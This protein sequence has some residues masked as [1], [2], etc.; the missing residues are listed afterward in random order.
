MKFTDRCIIAFLIFSLFVGISPAGS[1]T[2]TEAAKPVTVVITVKVK[3][4]EEVLQAGTKVNHPV[5]NANLLIASYPSPLLPWQ[6]IKD[7]QTGSD[8]DPN[9]SLTGAD[10]TAT[11]RVPV[12]VQQDSSEISVED[13]QQARNLVGKAAKENYNEAVYRFVDQAFKEEKIDLLRVVVEAIDAQTTTTNKALKNNVLSYVLDKISILEDPVAYKVRQHYADEAKQSAEER[14]EDQILAPYARQAAFIVRD[15]RVAELVKEK[16]NLNLLKK[17]TGKIPTDSIVGMPYEDAMRRLDEI[18]AELAELHRTTWFYETE[19]KNRIRKLEEERDRLLLIPGLPENDAFKER[20]RKKIDE[21]FVLAQI[22]EQKNQVLN[23][24]H[25]VVTDYQNYANSYIDKIPG[26]LIEKKRI[27]DQMVKKA[28]E[29]ENRAL[30]E[31]LAA[32]NSDPLL[33]AEIE[34]EDLTSGPLW[35]VLA[36]I[37]D[38][39]YTDE[40][41]ARLTSAAL[42]KAIERL[43]QKF[44]EQIV[45]LTGLRTFEELMEEF[46]LHVYRRLLA[47]VAK[48]YAPI[49]GEQ[50]ITSMMGGLGSSFD[51]QDASDE[52]W[53]LILHGGEAFVLAVTAPVPLV[54]LGLGL[55]FIAAEGGLALMTLGDLSTAQAAAAVGGLDFRGLIHYQD[56][57]E[58]R[59]E[60]I[61]LS[62]ALLPLDFLAWRAAVA[63]TKALAAQKQLAKD[64]AAAKAAD[65]VAGTSDFHA[66]KTEVASERPGGIQDPKARS[67]GGTE[68]AD[69]VATAPPP[70]KGGGTETFLPEVEGDIGTPIDDLWSKVGEYNATVNKQSKTKDDMLRIVG[71]K[72][73]I[74]EIVEQLKGTT[75]V[76]PGLKP[77]QAPQRVILGEWLG[78]GTFGQVFRVLNPDGTPID[79]IVVKIFYTPGAYRESVAAVEG[80]I[81]GAKVLDSI[82]DNPIYSPAIRSAN[83]EGGPPI[84]VLQK[85]PDGWYQVSGRK[86]T[87]EEMEKLIKSDMFLGNN[88]VKY[89]DGHLGNRIFHPDEDFAGLGEQ[90][91]IFGSG[92]KG[93]ELEIIVDA[94]ADNPSGYRLKNLERSA[95]TYDERVKFLEDAHNFRRTMWENKGLIVY[96][97]GVDAAGKPVFGLVNKGELDLHVVKKHDPDLVRGKV[98]REATDANGKPIL[99]L[100]P[101]FSDEALK[102][103]ATPKPVTA[104]ATA[105]QPPAV[106]GTPQTKD[107]TKVP[108]VGGAISKG[109]GIT[110]D[111]EDE[112]TFNLARQVSRATHQVAL[113]KKAIEEGNKEKFD[114]AAGNLDTIVQKMFEGA[115]YY[116]EKDPQLAKKWTSNANWGSKTQERL[117][118]EF[119]KKRNEQTATG[120][121][122]P[123]SLEYDRSDY[124][125]G[126]GNAN[127][128]IP[129]D[130]LNSDQTINMNIDVTPRSG[131][132]FGIQKNGNPVSIPY[133]LK[134][135]LDNSFEVSNYH[136]QAVRFPDGMEDEI[137]KIVESIPNV[138]YVE[139]NF[140]R[141]KATP[142]DPYLRSRA[143]WKQDYDDQW[144]IKRVGFTASPDSAWTLV[145]QGSPVVVAVIDTGLDWNHLDISWDNIW[146]NKN[147]IPKNGIDDDKNG[148]VDDLIGWNFISK[149]NNPWDYDGHGTFVTGVIAATE[150]NATGI[151]GVNPHAR[152]MV[153]KALNGFG[154]TRASY[155]SEAIV[156]AAN[157]GARV[158]NLSAGGDR[159]TRT[160]QWA[161]DYAYSKGVVVVVAAGNEALDVSDYSPAGLNNVISVAASDFSNSRAVYSNYGNGID[162]SAPGD[163]VL[164]LRARR[165]DLLRDIPGVKYIAG[166]SY[167]GKDKRY[168]RASGTS[169][170]APIVAGTASLLFSMNP[171]LTNEEVER[172][173]LHSATDVD[174]PG[175]DQHTGYGVLN[176]R[177]AL[178]ADSKYFLITE[179]QGAEVVMK[180]GRPFVQVKGTAVADQFKDAYIEIGRGKKPDQWKR[181]DVELTQP[182]REGALGEIPA[183]EL[184]GSKDWTIRLVGKHENG[185]TQEGW[186]FL[187]LQ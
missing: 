65:T 108:A 116:A 66:A 177:A 153:L 166:S 100:D 32:L 137:R 47:R 8:E 178:E 34:V 180:A 105:A 28:K 35:R 97:E 128:T 113:A 62:V 182:V 171:K 22:V 1:G 85:W 117:T 37:R 101:D 57:L 122:T 60:S 23:E 186:F 185:R 160:E 155:I 33:S 156:Y 81:Q 82:K 42:D 36:Q 15:F 43:D 173:L 17:G 68:L 150:N 48:A 3:A 112:D 103:A 107:P 16:A 12:S 163:D 25:K 144:A 176:A 175:K 10:G 152:I 74:L 9:Q 76:I 106:T 162:I 54:S 86:L 84:L 119:N 109:A 121:S 39:N 70:K 146:N 169:F 64:A 88:G 95:P 165:T 7:E 181:I 187:T 136:I 129:A 99:E 14:F 52:E 58:A 44:N 94:W 6:S 96:Q 123:V 158:I 114:E 140:I 118:D 183:S 120:D 61:A 18:G 51:A 132:I 46:R 56:L 91:R 149:N 98:Y 83:P 40:E 157:N 29:E 80:Q 145:E 161:V 13:D 135:F 115:Q 143:S 59:V 5:A 26:T 77:G 89:E 69:E 125:L 50:L 174:V 110:V 170:A 90:H 87:P 124:A 24:K 27:W 130:A 151:A 38:G 4:T 154:H 127:I 142:N 147:E 2:E 31:Y 102:A 126:G 184:A 19:K 93:G 172:M 141:T 138:V 79:D 131:F 134:P 179:I 11:F 78:G 164:S 20:R 159:L 49:F 133:E 55:I 148:Y 72:K 111:T 45:H 63:E 67:P 41:R 139:L 167:V 30:N 73:Q 92:E 71:L 21:L 53:E 168:Y 75:I 104:P